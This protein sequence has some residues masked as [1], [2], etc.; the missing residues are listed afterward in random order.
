MKPQ[1]TKSCSPTN[2]IPIINDAWAASFAI[3]ANSLKAIA[4]RG[5]GRLTIAYC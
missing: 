5:W 1:E 3:K 2:I 4:A